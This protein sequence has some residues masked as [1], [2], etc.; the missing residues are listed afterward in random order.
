MDGL[1]YDDNPL[2]VATYWE[3]QAHLYAS[4]LQR[5]YQAER[6]ERE[7]LESAQAQLLRYAEDVRLTFQA[8]RARRQQIQQAY[9]ETIRMLAAAVE[10]RDP[11][12]GGHISRVTRLCLTIARR[13][14]WHSEQLSQVEMGAILHDI[15]KI[16]IDDAILRKPA[17]LSDEEWAQ[18]RQHPEIGSQILRGISFLEPVVPYVRHHHER[19]DGTGYPDGLVGEN[20]P[21]GGRLIAVADAFD[22]MTSDR[23]YHPGMP[24]PPAVAEI[25]RMAGRQFDPVIVRAFVEAYEAGEVST[26]EA[27]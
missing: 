13:L 12:T 23:P 6:T 10:A 19:F 9:L 17:K 2:A 11:Y 5:I 3:K 16:N 24:F 20:I 1:N 18:M 7:A 22:A 4:E 27:T 14:G 21:I 8:E 25:C 15:G 26:E